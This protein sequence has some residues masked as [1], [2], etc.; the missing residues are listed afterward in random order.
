MVWY[1]LGIMSSWLS[2]V[3]LLFKE[4]KLQGRKSARKWY[5]T[6]AE[7]EAKT[8]WTAPQMTYYER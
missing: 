6:V 2:S 3:R 5:I 7:I 8:G 4:G 1:L